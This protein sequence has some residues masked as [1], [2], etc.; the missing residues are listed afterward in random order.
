MAVLTL[1]ELQKLTAKLSQGM[2]HAELIF[3]A[4]LQ[5]WS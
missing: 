5:K 3:V 4:K 2:Q 1:T